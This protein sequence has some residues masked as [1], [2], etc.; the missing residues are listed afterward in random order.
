M[1]FIVHA[2]GSTGNLYQVTSENHSLVIDPGIPIA[3]IK[4][5]LRYKTASLSG[6]LI[7]H[8]HA[9][10][11]KG[12]LSLA[13]MGVD[14]WMTEPTASSLKING[15]RIHHIEPLQ[16]FEIGDFSVLPFETQHD[17]PGSVG[18]LISDGD[19]KLLFA[20]DTFYIHHRFSGV[21]IYA[22]ECNYAKETM[23]KWLHPERK[24][25]LYKS[26][27]SLE[28]VIKFLKAND[29]SQASEIHLI[30]MSQ[31]NADPVW[32]MDQIQRATGKPVI[33]HI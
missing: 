20:T 9:D 24:R 7:S 31:Q 8:S 13:K 28:N 2:S 21:N 25:R 29:L 18:F 14:C 22:I 4:K 26:H 23:D 5:A 3:K 30:H 32:F 33:T 12:A 15:H 11:S 19:T 10:H 17:C 16:Q 27:F 6:A 1:E